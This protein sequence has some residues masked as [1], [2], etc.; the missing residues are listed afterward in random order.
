MEKEPEKCGMMAL[1]MKGR[2]QEW[3]NV[4][5]LRKLEKARKQ[6]PPG[7]SKEEHSPAGTFVFSLVRP[8][9]NFW[10]EQWD[11]S[12]MLLKF[13]VICYNSNGTWTQLDLS[14]MGF[15]SASAIKQSAYNAG[16]MRDMY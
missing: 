6:I 9:L 15:P 11:N 8:I 14:L 13:V 7:S 1:K 5:T 16:D 2:G 10:L 4:A 3:R 12:Y